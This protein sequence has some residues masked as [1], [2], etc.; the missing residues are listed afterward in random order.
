MRLCRSEQEY[1]DLEQTGVLKRTIGAY[2]LGQRQSHVLDILARA[3]VWSEHFGEWVPMPTGY[4]RATWNDILDHLVKTRLG[5]RR[6]LDCGGFFRSTAASQCFISA[7]GLAD[8]LVAVDRCPHCAETNTEVI[9]CTE[10]TV[11]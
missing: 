2:A 5:D 1:R 11:V 8:R 6:C 3:R 10:G 4:D 9:G 7:G